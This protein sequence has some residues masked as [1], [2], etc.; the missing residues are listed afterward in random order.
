MGWA[1]TE[2]DCSGSGW[3]GEGTDQKLQF[4]YIEFTMAIRNSCEDVE[5]AVDYM[6]EI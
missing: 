1:I 4:G 6:S 2:V 5:E 3:W